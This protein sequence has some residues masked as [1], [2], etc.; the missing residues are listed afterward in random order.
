VTAIDRRTLLKLVAAGASGA[1]LGEATAAEE[2]APAVVATA[3]AAPPAGRSLSEKIAD[4]IV[5][6]RFEDLPADVIRKAKEQ[7]VFFFGR[8]FEVSFT[9]QGRQ[10]RRV[11]PPSAAD[12]ETA[13]VIGNR[14]RL[15]PS[16]AAFANATLFG[17]S[18]S[19]DDVLAYAD[20][21]AG[22]ITLPTALAIGEARRVSGRE[23]I[24]A[25]VLGYEVLGRLGRASLGWTAPQPRRSTNIFG[26]YGPVTVAGRLLRLDAERMAHAI[27]AGAHLCMGIAEGSMMQHYYSLVAR[28]G[29]FA[30]QLV[31]AGAI[32]YSR[33]TLEGELGLYRSFFGEVPPALP[34][35][36]EQFDYREILSAVQK[37]YNG[38]GHNTTPIE[39]FADELGKTGL[40]PQQVAKIQA[41][42]PAKGAR[43]REA[44]LSSRGPFDPPQRAHSSLTYC[45]ARVL[46]DGGL[47]I[48]HFDDTSIVND[49]D[50]ARVMQKIDIAFEPGHGPRW[51]KLTIHTT[52]GRKLERQSEFFTFDFPAAAWGDWLSASGKR[53]LTSE[54]L[55]QLLDLISNL[56][57]VDDVSK[58]LTA[59]TPL[60]NLYDA[61]NK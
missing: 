42:L 36:V 49:S 50:V 34:K 40:T 13:T 1:V 22:V 6:A 52:D 60:Q 18:L 9:D 45:L 20:I 39:M 28:N 16:D 15:S 35:L 12:G 21:H 7:I 4:Q 2:A 10:M 43:A 25:L 55:A 44:E 32:C 58:L 41:V 51:A 24:L 56:E 5:R 26:G 23:L 3:P 57:R 46:L 54:Q 61:V 30:A 17:A 14:L 48:P 19:K 53:L 27:G 38:T 37:R 29:T 59:A 8:A 47:K 11:L 31:E 33:T